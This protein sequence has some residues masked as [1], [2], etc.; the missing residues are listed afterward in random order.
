M[1]KWPIVWQRDVSDAV[2]RLTHQRLSNCHITNSFRVRETPAE[3]FLRP[4]LEKKGC[5]AM[6]LHRD[7]VDLEKKNRFWI[8]SILGLDLI[9]FIM[10]YSFYHNSIVTVKNKFIYT[11]L[12]ILIRIFLSFIFYYTG[13]ITVLKIQ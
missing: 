9:H 12:L 2:A 5:R 6:V 11:Q 1:Q 7:Y 4:L 3:R 10:S 8:R 13:N